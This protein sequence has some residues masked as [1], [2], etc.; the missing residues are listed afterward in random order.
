MEECYDLPGP[1]VDARQVGAFLQIAIPTGER[2]VVSASRSSVLPGD[3]VFNVKC[4]A[5]GRLG[6]SAILAATAGAPPNRV[7]R[8]T[9]AGCWRV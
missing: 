3:N 7:R 8:L 4:A 6:Q 9:H 2:K 1:W 5:E